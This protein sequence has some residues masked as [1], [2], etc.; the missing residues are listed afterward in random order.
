MTRGDCLY[1]QKMKWR[2]NDAVDSWCEQE[3]TCLHGWSLQPA[4]KPQPEHSDA[5]VAARI[6]RHLILLFQSIPLAY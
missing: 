4:F 6:L 2:M 1:L 3:V 5:V